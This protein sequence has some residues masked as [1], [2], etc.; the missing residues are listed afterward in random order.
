V[1]ELTD[2]QYLFIRL[3]KLTDSYTDWFR[4]ILKLISD[5]R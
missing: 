2:F 4:P 3:R 1:K 5:E